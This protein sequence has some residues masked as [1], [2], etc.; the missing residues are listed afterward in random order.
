MLLGLL[1]RTPT[2]LIAGDVLKYHLNDTRDGK[3]ID[4]NLTQS[5]VRTTHR[6][7]TFN[8]PLTGPIYAQP[9][10]VS[11]GPAGRAAFIVVTEQNAVVALDA[12]NGSPIWT[13]ALGNPVP[14]SQQW[15]GNIDP[16]GITGTPVIDPTA[17]VLYV[18]ALTTPD[19]G[20]T[21]RHLIFALSLD[22]GSTLAGWPLDVS[23]AITYLG[24]PFDSSVQNQ[25]GALLLSGGI[26]YVP[27]GGHW[28]D[29]GAYNGW[30][31]AVPVNNPAGATAWA[32][33]ASRGGVWAPGGLASDGSSIF[34]ATGNTDGVTTWSGGE[35]IIRLGPGATFSG[36]PTDY[37]APS[38]W[39]DLDENDEDLGGSGP[40]LVDVP[41][42]TPSQLVVALGKNGVAYLLN[43]NNLAGVGTGDGT[44][45]EGLFSLQ[46][47]DDEIINAAAAY[48][49]PSGTY[50]V[51]HTAGSGVG[52]PRISGDLVALKITGSAPPAITV[53]W[54][55][56]NNGF[57]SPIVTTTDGTSQPVVWSVG[58]TGDNLL[59]AF[60]GETGDVLFAG[61]GPAEQMTFVESYQTPIAVNGRI[62]VAGDDGLYAFTTQSSPDRPSSVQ[63]PALQQLKVTKRRSPS[64]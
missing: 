49:A 41:G 19:G 61:G 25:R 37:F 42:A 60:N 57:G 24:M 27:Y 3:Y 44:S 8:A 38:N 20:T 53:A 47:A 54:C 36:N 10:Y 31:V 18:D 58:A 40:V 51:F 9:L 52:C 34:A 16:L 56:N 6:D 30:V 46:V 43:R 29:C 28:G 62:F 2:G 5:A 59:H 13:S 14:L 26:L 15:C 50:V 63:R 33:Q 7:S 21:Q 11:S 4:P 35:A 32:T 45:G 39:Q 1:L 22:D 64:R 17:R 23:G 48:T 55:A 12:T